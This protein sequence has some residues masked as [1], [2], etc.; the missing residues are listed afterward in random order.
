MQKLADAIDRFKQN[1]TSEKSQNG[2]LA[3]ISST[4]VQSK[5]ILQPISFLSSIY[6]PHA[7]Y[8]FEQTPQNEI[9]SMK[10]SRLQNAVERD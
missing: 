2:S 9:E 1:E 4:R 8:I 6:S 3:C 7:T 5:F 10:P